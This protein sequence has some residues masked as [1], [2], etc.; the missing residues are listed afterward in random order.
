MSKSELGK[1]I[2]FGIENL[3]KIH[4]RMLDFVVLEVD[5]ELKV[6]AMTY[7]CLGYYNAIEH[8]ML[9][10]IKYLK[11]TKPSGAFSHRDTLVL[12][13]KLLR[14]ASIDTESE[15]VKVI[16]SLM[17]FRH[18]ATKIYGFLID[19]SKLHTVIKDIELQHEN[20]IQT[21]LKLFDTL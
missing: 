20:I 16:E 2:D 18:V 9:R 21:F 4:S 12:Y 7:E 15:T 10:I 14:E 5:H 3:N 19:W 17:A 13:E 1:E 11:M 8:L 6:S